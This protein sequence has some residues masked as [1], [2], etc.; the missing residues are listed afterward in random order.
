MN[1]PEAIAIYFLILIIIITFSPIS[2]KFAPRAKNKL[3][4]IKNDDYTDSIHLFRLE[5]FAK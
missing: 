2:Y 1:K 4:F 5:F 3:I